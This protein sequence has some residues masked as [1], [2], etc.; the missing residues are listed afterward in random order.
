MRILRYSSQW[1][2]IHKVSCIVRTLVLHKFI[3]HCW[4][5]RQLLDDVFVISRI[6]KVEVETL[7][8]L[9]ITKTE[10]KMYVFKVCVNS[11][12]SSGSL[13]FFL[14]HLIGKQLLT[15]FVDFLCSVCP[16]LQLFFR[17]PARPTKQTWKSCFYFVTDGKQHKARELDMITLRNHAPSLR[18][19]PCLLALPRQGCFARR[20]VCDSAA[21]ISYWWRNPMFT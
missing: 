6:I 5:F 10:C 1:S 17:W 9:D 3:L 16:C 13:S 8:I 18:K 2:F 19:H 11:F 14:F 7:I 21:E 4:N 20:N 12:F 15:P